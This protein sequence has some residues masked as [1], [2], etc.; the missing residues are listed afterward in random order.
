MNPHAPIRFSVRGADGVE[1]AYVAGYLP[2]EEGIEV[3][4]RLIA[5]GAEPLAAAVD[6]AVDQGASR[7]LPTRWKSCGN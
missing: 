4:L 1:H 2:A 6:G 3:A 7:R 5:L